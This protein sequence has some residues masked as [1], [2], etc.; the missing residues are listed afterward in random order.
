MDTS[1]S[2]GWITITY[3]YTP[4]LTARV[5]EGANLLESA[6]PWRTR[7]KSC[8]EAFRWGKSRR[9]W[10]ALVAISRMHDAAHLM[11]GEGD[12]HKWEISSRVLLHP[13]D[14]FKVL[15]SAI[16]GL[17]ERSTATIFE[18]LIFDPGSRQRPRFFSHFSR[19][20]LS[21]SPCRPC[22]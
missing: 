6:I 3:D 12:I 13:Q 4:D 14:Q 5:S 18:W 1:D 22:S 11:A 20:H 10:A 17:T 15:L 21:Y 2:R 9:F 8:S 7:R 19:L 16:S